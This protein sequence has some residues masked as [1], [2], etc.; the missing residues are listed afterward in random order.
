MLDQHQDQ[1][2]IRQD[3]APRLLQRISVDFYQRI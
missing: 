2:L 3:P 1:R